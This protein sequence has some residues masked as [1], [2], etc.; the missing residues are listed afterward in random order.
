MHGFWLAP[1]MVGL[2]IAVGWT[3]IGPSILA[4]IAVTAVML[5]VQIFVGRRFARARSETA[6]RTDKRVNAMNDIL[7]GMRTVK[8]AAWETPLSK[9]VATLRKDET[10]RIWVALQLKVFTLSFFFVGTHLPTFAAIA[11]FAGTGGTLTPAIVF[12]VFSLF[13]ALRMTT[14]GW[15]PMGINGYNE[16]AICLKRMTDLL[17]LDANDN[18]RILESGKSTNTSTSTSTST[19]TSRATLSNDGINSN[20]KT[21]DSLEGIKGSLTVSN[22]QCKWS[23]ESADDENSSPI[24]NGVDFTIGIKPDG[25]GGETLVILG[26]VGSGKS[27]L[28]LVLLNE[29]DPTAGTVEIN[30][31]ATLY[32]PQK[33][34][35]FPG[36]FLENITFTYRHDAEWLVQC[37]GFTKSRV[38]CERSKIGSAVSLGVKPAAV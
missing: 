13:G 24:L 25:T 9:N 36:S 32:A 23:T 35:I 3:Q 10:S 27:T 2:T 5:P 19:N 11:V 17:T 21:S 33:P 4:G 34:W 7:H 22:L 1:I 37:S 38:V 6:T 26:P 16:L 12:S 8:M 28:L 29:L 15:L 14:A 20:S 31:L 30:G 18:N